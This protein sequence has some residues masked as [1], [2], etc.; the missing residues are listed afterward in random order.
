MILEM[1]PLSLA[2]VKEL[3]GDLEEKKDL[4]DYLKKFEKV[5]KDNAE[6]MMADLRKIDNMKLKDEYIVKIVDFK[7]GSPEE[8]NKIFSDVT[9]NE[10]EINEILEI[11][12]RY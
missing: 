6:K 2:E 11:V 3:A 12:K 5:S 9:L 10:E 8:L 7:P 1:K 4:R